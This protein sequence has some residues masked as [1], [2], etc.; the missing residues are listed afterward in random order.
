M[1]IDV[2]E[3]LLHAPPLW[4]LQG[5]EGISPQCWRGFGSWHPLKTLKAKCVD[6]DVSILLG[7]HLHL[8][9]TGSAHSSLAEETGGWPGKQGK[10]GSAAT[11]NLPPLQ[12]AEELLVLQ[13]PLHLRLHQHPAHVHHLFHS[14]SQALHRVAE[15]QPQVSGIW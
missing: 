10:L 6:R 3:L 9:A 15:L 7:R 4:S 13:K 2:G 1:G 12:A 8:Y 5:L 11:A 14:Q